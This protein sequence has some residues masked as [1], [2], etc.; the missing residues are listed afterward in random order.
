MFNQG[1][2]NAG[3]AQS[4]KPD[5]EELIAQAG[6][7]RDLLQKALDGFT[8]LR[9]V[10]QPE[11]NHR[12]EYPRFSVYELEALVKTEGAFTEKQINR[13]MKQSSES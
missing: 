12:G 13:W 8:A 4:C 11:I 7:K 5:Y 1:G 6:H 9:E 2:Y 10:T 3:P